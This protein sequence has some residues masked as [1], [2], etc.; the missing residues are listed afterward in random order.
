MF[1]HS[2]SFPEESK[3]KLSNKFQWRLKHQKILHFLGII[4]MVKK[5]TELSNYESWHCSRKP[6]CGRIIEFSLFRNF[7]FRAFISS[8]TM[9]SMTSQS[10]WNFW[11]F[12]CILLLFFTTGHSLTLT[13][14]SK[15][16]QENGEFL[17]YEV[18]NIHDR[19]I[20]NCIE[21]L[22]CR[23]LFPRIMQINIGYIIL[24][25]LYSSTL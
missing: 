4:L 11:N 3:R 25:N 19:A 13:L 21:D 18:A 15:F 8:M 23:H 12:Q 22:L 6:S 10:N 5:H 1:F 9:S 16:S 20:L 24:Y 17:N 2:L 7:R 14:L